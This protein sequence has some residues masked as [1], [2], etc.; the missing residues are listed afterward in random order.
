M[1]VYICIMR[2]NGDPEKHSYILGA[3]TDHNTASKWG[4]IEEEYRGHKYKAEVLEIMLDAEP[5]Q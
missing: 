1:N 4:A 5:E 3:Y 2:R